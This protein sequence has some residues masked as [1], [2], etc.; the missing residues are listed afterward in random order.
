M[1]TRLNNVENTD[2]IV[3]QALTRDL[4]KHDINYMNS[5]INE[6]VNKALTKA[7]KVVISTIVNREDKKDIGVKAG[8]VNAHIKYHYINHENVIVWDNHN[9]NDRKFRLRDGIHL[10]PHG[11]SIFATNLKYKIAEALK[12]DVF[13]KENTRGRRGYNGRRTFFSDNHG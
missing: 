10:T 6:V 13:K 8:L 12:I 5:R 2:V 11:T 3:I 7:K 1:E 9:L 4:S